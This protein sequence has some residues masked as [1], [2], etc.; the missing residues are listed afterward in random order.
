MKIDS[1]NQSQLPWTGARY[2]PQLTGD[3]QLEHLHRY[4]LAAEYAKD[5]DVLDIGSGEG[6]GSAILAKTARSV[7]GVDIATEAIQHASIRY[8]LDNVRFQPGSCAEI[9]LDDHSIDL[10]VSFET[11]EHH[12]Q[13]EAMMAEIK[14]VL[15]PGGVLII[16]TP[17]KGEYSVLPNTQNSFRV[18]ELFKDELEDLIRAHFN[19]QALLFQRVVFGSGIVPEAGTFSFA[20]RNIKNTDDARPSLLR[21]KYLVAIASDRALPALSGGLLEQT[22]EESEI[23]KRYATEYEKR[24]EVFTQLNYKVHQLEEQLQSQTSQST[25]RVRQLEEQLQSQTSQSTGR[26]RQ[27]EEQLHSQASQSTDQVRR[28]E[29]QLHSQAS[30]FADNIHQLQELTAQ[31]N[32]ALRAAIIRGQPGRLRQIGNRLTGGGLRSLGTRLLKRVRITGNQMTGGGLRNLSRRLT[33]KILRNA[34]PNPET[35]ALVHRSPEPLNEVQDASAPVPVKITETG[36]AQ[37]V[38]LFISA[39]PGTP[40]NIYR[41]VRPV[42]AL[43]A[44]GAQSSWIPIDKALALHEEIAKAD[45]IILWRVAWDELVASIVKTA[46]QGGAKVVFDADDLMINPGYARIEVIDGIRSMGLIESQVSEHYS[47]VQ[48]TMLAA[49]YCTAPT[50][51]LAGEFRRFS[52]SVMV[53]PNGFDHT[54]YKISRRSVRRRRRS[55]ASAPLLRIGYA[56]G[57]RTHQRDFGVAAPAVARVLRE[58][59]HCRLVLFKSAQEL[60]PIVDIEEFADFQGLEDRIEWH[61]LVPLSQL[62]EKL[63]L[64]DIN[65]APLETGNVFCEAKSELKFFEAALVDVPTIASPTGPF[66][67]AIRNAVTGFL[68]DKSQEWYS[69]LLRLVDDPALR[70]RMARAAHRAVLWHYGPRRRTEAM[71]SALSQWRGH[72]RDATHAFAFD[73]YRT[74]ASSAPFD[75]QI[76]ESEVVFESDKLGDADLTVVIPLYNYAQY[77]EE[78]LESVHAQNLELFDL[79]VV[80]DASSDASLAK[81]LEWARR[82][83][84]R[85]NRLMVLRNKANAG[86]GTTRNTGIDAADTPYV[87]LLDADNRLRPNCAAA[88]LSAI[89][90]SGAAFAYPPIQ[91]FGDNSALM[92]TSSFQPGRLI[93][94]NYIDALALVTKEAWAAVGG[95][96]TFRLGWED[97]DFWCRLVEIG[98]WGCRAGENPLADYRAHGQSMSRTITNTQENAAE[99]IREMKERHPWLNI[100]GPTGAPADKGTIAKLPLGKR[101]AL[102]VLGVG[103]SGTSCLAHLLNVLGAKLPKEVLGPNQG[104]PSGYWEP[105]R[106]LEINEEIL[107]SIGRSWHDP[108]P[109]APGWFRSKEAYAFHKRLCAEIVSSYGNAPL[110]LIKEPRVCRLLPLYLDV[111]DTLGIEPIAILHL[112]HPVEVIRSIHQRDGGD[113]LTHELRW[114]RHLIESENAS[115]NCVRVWTSFEQLLDDWKMTAQSISRGLGITWPNEPE[116]VSHEA[117]TV[118]QPQHRHFKVADDPAPLPLGPLTIRAWQA[119]QQGLDGDEAG[120]R[121]LFDEIRIPINEIDRLSFPTQE[122]TP[123]LSAA[124]AAE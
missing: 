48:S 45:V 115:R 2:V 53:L 63:A 95:Y 47:R 118:L 42:E 38:V 77:I 50:E 44:G 104:N 89:C 3:I 93:G 101:A 67:R 26:V 83:A 68:A 18:S 79:I 66:R 4:F 43:R 37:P 78:A 71:I 33:S 92:G 24:S 10:V 55:P 22:I 40:G 100:T 9:P 112:R 107:A 70:L 59:P 74:K 72:P 85:F 76:A 19:Y 25:G 27:L 29:E 81:V 117:A 11:I 1:G 64:F 12:D 105:L 20:S 120:A 35:K 119:A 110:I 90:E 39:E 109:I 14:R 6:F 31:L 124:L 30:Q 23:V 13:H 62:P 102:L 21:P 54:T 15:R 82:Y 41:V 36:T 58:R 65:I 87:L 116:K 16:S 122:A 94:G 52:N 98:L 73:W 96:Q 17:N 34:M 84:Q 108:R 60:L 32:L 88:C 28:L 49:D 123:L 97:Y 80:D 61:D 51:E 57:S 7:V 46:R 86:L 113:L 8:Q 106:L 5:K 121:I 103:R 91:R 56:G 69:A 75:I 114:L 111:L 99:L